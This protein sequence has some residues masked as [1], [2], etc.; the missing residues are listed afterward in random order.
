MVT[1]GSLLLVFITCLLTESKV[2]VGC[3]ST[4]R[5]MESAWSLRLTPIVSCYCYQ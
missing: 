2:H 3:L 5:W 4:W 1:E